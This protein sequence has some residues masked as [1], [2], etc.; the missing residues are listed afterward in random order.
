MRTL[1]ITQYYYY[2][3]ETGKLCLNHGELA[4][5]NYA[6]DIKLEQKQWFMT[7][8]QLSED[9]VETYT[10]GLCTYAQAKDRTYDEFCDFVK[11][12]ISTRTYEA[13]RNEITAIFEGRYARHYV[14]TSART[15]LRKDNT[16]QSH[17]DCFDFAR[18]E[19][20][21]I[22]GVENTRQDLVNWIKANKREM[23][24]V[25]ITLLN[26]KL[27]KVKSELTSNFFKCYRCTLTRDLTLVYDLE[28][29]IR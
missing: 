9:E 24:T 22:Q 21:M 25:A 14:L 12:R 18:I 11:A 26:C 3:I 15:I 23:D 2:D 5:A 6:R 7:C 1:P 8:I 16:I 29:K 27:T 28:L 20:P 19:I 4:W 10:H 17:K 13:K